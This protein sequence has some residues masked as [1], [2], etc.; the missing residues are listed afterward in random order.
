ME[1]ECHYARRHNTEDDPP[2][3]VDCVADGVVHEGLPGPTWT[4]EEEGL[5][6]MCFNG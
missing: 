6:G 3:V 5:T 4:I 1:K 2:L